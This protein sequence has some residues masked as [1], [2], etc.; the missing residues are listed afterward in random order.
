MPLARQA[1]TGGGHDTN[2]G[3]PPRPRPEVRRTDSWAMDERTR[4]AAAVAAAG[5]GGVRRSSEPACSPGHASDLY[6]RVGG[7]LSNL[8][9]CMFWPVIEVKV[10]SGMT[11]QP[12]GSDC[13]GRVIAEAAECRHRP[14]TG[15]GVG[16]RFPLAANVHRGYSLLSRP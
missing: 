4:E 1:S 6:V 13:S 10:G 12:I 3:R 15:C 2:E 16:R 11:W 7:P 14:P 9:A 8:G 5:P